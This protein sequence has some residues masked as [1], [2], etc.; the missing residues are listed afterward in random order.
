[1]YWSP[2]IDISLGKATDVLLLSS[3]LSYSLADSD[4]SII[5]RLELEFMWIYRITLML[6]VANLANTK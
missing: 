5:V 6:L 2:L 4:L 3:C 1:M